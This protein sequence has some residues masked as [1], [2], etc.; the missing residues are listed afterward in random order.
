[1]RPSRAWLLLLLAPL[2]QAEPAGACSCVPPRAVLISPAPGTPAPL[3]TRV[4]L[5]L[6][7]PGSGAGQEELVLR[8]RGGA[9][10][11][12][13][14]TDSALGALTH[15]ELVPE[16]PLASETR[17]E[18]AVVAKDRHPSTLVFGTFKTEK[19]ADTTAP[20]GGK[21]DKPVVYKAKNWY[22]GSCG[23]GTPWATLSV[24]EGKD[25]GRPGARLVYAVWSA[26]GGGRLDTSSAPKAFLVASEGTL[27]IGQTSL[28]DPDDYPLPD[29]GRA[30]LGF[31]LVDE[32]GN[33]GA[34]QRVVF[35]ISAARD[36]SRRRP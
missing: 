35:D 11:A 26:D 6:P 29:K 31:A 33:R 9:P 1:M 7:G 34:V 25:Q 36:P 2:F 19:E 23:I 8:A 14:R 16:A 21:L 5:A 15:I 18:L 22:G 30:T 28:C 24:A 13:K 12:V 20:A 17:Y 32:A 4:R 3:N 27:T 10:V